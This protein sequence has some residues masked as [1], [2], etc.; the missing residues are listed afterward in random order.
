[1]DQTKG[2]DVRIR[3]GKAFRKLRKLGLIA[4]QN[5]A[6]CMGCGFAEL[7]PLLTPDPEIRGI[8]FY[9][10]LQEAI[11]DDF[12]GGEDPEDVRAEYATLLSRWVKYGES[13]AIEFDLDTMTA[14]V[15]EEK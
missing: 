11:G 15:L 1:M 6:C 2:Y 10:A 4:K 12:P 3:I 9:H 8:V 14:T 13:V 5:F 7:T